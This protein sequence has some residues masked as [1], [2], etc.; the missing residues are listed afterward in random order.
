MT[1]DWSRAQAAKALPDME[2]VESEPKGSGANARPGVTKGTK[3]L[4]RSSAK[5]ADGVAPSPGPSIEDLRRKYLGSAGRD[6]PSRALGRSSFS[7]VAGSHPPTAS[8]DEED[9]IDVIRVRSKRPS[10]DSA[11]DPGPR[12]IITSKRHGPLGSQG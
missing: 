4:S 7:D 11:E 9:E 1:K 10:A 5:G 2:I 3:S 8:A 12:T 6:A